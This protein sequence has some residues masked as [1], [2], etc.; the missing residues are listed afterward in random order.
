M[1]YRSRYSPIAHESKFI[2]GYHNRNQVQFEFPVD[3]DDVGDEMIAA[4]LNKP[5]TRRD[6]D[7]TQL[8]FYIAPSAAAALVHH[9]FGDRQRAPGRGSYVVLP[10]TDLYGNTG[11]WVIEN[12]GGQFAMEFQYRAAM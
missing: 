12:Q 2:P 3:A 11:R 4:V 8:I 6:A 7:G 1:G 5:R 9:F 10:E